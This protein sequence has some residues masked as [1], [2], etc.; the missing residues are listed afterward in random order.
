[1]IASDHG[2]HLSVP[3]MALY[4]L[5]DCVRMIASGLGIYVS[6]PW[7]ASNSLPDCAGC[8]VCYRLGFEVTYSSRSALPGVW[9]VSSHHAHTKTA[10]RYK[11]DTNIASR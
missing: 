5:P 9:E 3:W 6:V 8:K 10:K 4:S 2:I 1:M 11:A 7:M